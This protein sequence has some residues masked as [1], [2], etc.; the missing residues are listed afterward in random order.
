MD[1]EAYVGRLVKDLVHSWCS[2]NGC[3]VVIKAVW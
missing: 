2:V 3:V 1:K